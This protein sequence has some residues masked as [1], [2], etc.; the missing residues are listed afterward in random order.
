MQLPS[1]LYVSV[2]LYN[3]F[4]KRNKLQNVLNIVHAVLENKGIEKTVT[5]TFLY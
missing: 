1:S 3:L 2:N 5:S 4:V